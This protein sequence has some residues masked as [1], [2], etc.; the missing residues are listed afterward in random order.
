MKEI[1]KNKRYALGWYNE[2]VTHLTIKEYDEAKEF[3]E[4]A[5][6]VIPDHPD[7][8]IGFGDVQYACGNFQEAFQYYISALHAEPENYIAWLKAGIAL[9]KLSKFNEALEI[10]QNLLELSPYDGEIWYAR[11]LALIGMG[12]EQEAKDSFIHARRYRPNQ[13]ALW[14]SLS[15]LEPLHEKAIPL[16]QR[17]HQLDPENLDILAELVRHLFALGRTEEAIQFCRKAQKIAPESQRIKEL[18]QQCLDTLS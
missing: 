17:G 10:F 5:L 16:L 12:K 6:G 3:F 1:P 8:L 4:K 7:F 9:L 2:G 15:Q 18:L 11:G 13:P 14:Y